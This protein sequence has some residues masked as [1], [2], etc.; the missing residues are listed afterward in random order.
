MAERQASRPHPDPAQLEQYLNDKLDAVA[1]THVQ[2]HLASCTECR[3]ALEQC[4]A[5]GQ[6]A[7]ELR[8]LVVDEGVGLEDRS[9]ATFKAGEGREGRSA[10]EVEGLRAWAPLGPPRSGGYIGTFG[11]YDVV[12]ILGRGGM[13]V[14]LKCY[15]ESLNRTVAIKVLRPEL[16]S[17]EEAFK[18]FQSEAKAVAQLNHPNIVAVHATAQVVDT[19]FLAMQYV[20]GVTLSDLIRWQGPLDPRHIVDICSQVALALS[21]AH[22]RDLVHRDVKPSNILVEHD[23]GRAVLT[24]FGLARSLADPSRLTQVG[25]VLGTPNYMSPEQ[26]EARRTDARSDIFSLGSVMYEMCT[27]QVPFRAE[28]PRATLSLIVDSDPTPIQQ[29]NPDMPTWI[30]KVVDRAMAKDP[31]KR[32]QMAG[33]LQASLSVHEVS[34][35]G[36]H[37]TGGRRWPGLWATITRTHRR[38]SWSL[39]IGLA[40]LVAI[41][42]PIGIAHRLALERDRAVTATREADRQR[43]F[44]REPDWQAVLPEWLSWQSLEEPPELTSA[45]NWES[46]SADGF[47]T[48]KEMSL[49][50]RRLAVRRHHA[51]AMDFYRKMGAPL[52]NAYLAYMHSKVALGY[53]KSLPPDQEMSALRGEI[54]SA[55]EDARTHVS[56]ALRSFRS[57]YLQADRSGDYRAARANADKAMRLLTHRYQAHTSEYRE[58]RQMYDK[59]ERELRHGQ[60]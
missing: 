24:D 30:C 46:Q 13:G 50:E 12:S 41:V 44:G 26:A 15:E 5:D 49:A 52:G 54:V 11:T 27:G 32:F 28:T 8:Q 29:I 48:G 36:E 16:R 23:T 60:P 43:R 22:A 56:E 6:L 42:V 7:K 35:T 4:R 53:L 20:D 45:L 21:H 19:P 25:A 33:A 14:V 10:A 2:E 17:D 40:V 37:T 9:T 57:A 58:A 34:G 18:R 1:R 59:A 55:M 51:E 3:R 31:A 38:V 47:V 39:V